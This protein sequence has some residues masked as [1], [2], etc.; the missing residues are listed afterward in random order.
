[1]NMTH[2]VL[3]VDDDDKNIRL[4]KLIL[5]KDDYHIESASGGKEAL[6]MVARQEPD[7]ILLDIMM[8]GIDG[9]EVCKH[10]KADE[11]TK[12]IPVIMVT[13]L[14][15]KEHRLR[16]MDAGA[17]DFISKPIDQTELLI[18]LKSLLRIKMYHNRLKKSV[19]KLADKNKRLEE[20]E[21]QKEYLTRMIVHDMRNPLNAINM[22]T[23]LMLM[24]DKSDHDKLNVL[25]ETCKRS[26]TD[27]EQMIQNILDVRMMKENKL[28]LKKNGVH[29]SSVVKDVQ[30]QF[31][32][33]ID[34]SRISLTIGDMK[35]V[36]ELHADYEMVKRV[37][38]NLLNNAIRHTPEHGV[39]HIDVEHVC[40][41]EMIR[42]SMK[43][44]GEGIPEEVQKTIFNTYMRIDSGSNGA[45]RGRYGLGLAFCRMAVEAHGGRI[46][47]ESAGN[48]SGS[49]FVFEM[50]V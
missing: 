25:L 44:S 3:I 16:A 6:D 30:W 35:D 36:P 12:H 33:K 18:R 8:P 2:T 20:L 11:S 28:E 19:D 26:C 48:G 15:E 45:H 50:P 43:D 5:S 10:L 1:M 40:E 24:Q 13:A 23:D 21:A 42:F 39:I 17:D 4:I 37:I 38:A 41:K 34:D 46:W 9:F 14:Q 29:L 49:T 32:L 27:L 47:V 7:I 31:Q 22:S